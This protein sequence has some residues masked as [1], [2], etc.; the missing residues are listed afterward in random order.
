VDR[1]QAKVTRPGVE[2]R[3]RAGYFATP[4]TTPT[5]DS[6]ELVTPASTDPR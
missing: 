4:A 3:T 6:L 2:V 5:V 1:I